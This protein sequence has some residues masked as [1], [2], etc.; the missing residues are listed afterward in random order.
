MADDDEHKNVAGYRV[1][2]RIEDKAEN[3]V[4]QWVEHS[5]RLDI[6]MGLKIGAGDGHGN[7]FFSIV[8]S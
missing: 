7:V 6:A 3:G 5:A 1:G 4:R 2:P 8:N